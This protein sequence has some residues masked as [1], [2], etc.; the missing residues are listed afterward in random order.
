MIFSLYVTVTVLVLPSK[1]LVKGPGKRDFK[2][3]GKSMQI[4][5]ILSDLL[6]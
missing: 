5:G 2:A 6:G 4:R 1:V 3:T